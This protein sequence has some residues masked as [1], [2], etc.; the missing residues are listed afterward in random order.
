MKKK[1]NL[2]LKI[3]VLLLLILWSPKVI[4]ADDDIDRDDNIQ[5]I[6]SG[7]V[8]SNPRYLYAP[9]ILYDE[10]EKLFKLWACGNRGG[11]NIIYKQ[12]KTIDK[13]VND[14]WKIA[15]SPSRDDKSFDDD[16]TCDPSVIQVEN[17]YYLYYTG[18]NEDKDESWNKIGV[19]VSSDGGRTFTRL[20]SINPIIEPDSSFQGGYGTGQQAVTYRNGWYYMVYTDVE[21]GQPDKIQVIKSKS[22]TFENI[23]FIKQLNPSIKA[24]GPRGLSLDLAYNPS[25]D[26]FILV[27]NVST[28]GR[29]KVLITSY[30]ASD[31][32]YIEQSIF[33]HETNFRFGEG[34]G[35]LRNSSGEIGVYSKSG[36]H[37]FVFVAST[38]SPAKTRK[39]CENLGYT[40]CWVRGPM[41]FLIFTEDRKGLF[42]NF[43][44][45]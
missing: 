5:F 17:K 38:W 39:E 21:K 45:N 35:I 19:A 9:S 40:K 42:L 23:N 24:S 4:S 3:I 37:A 13:L 1:S 41:K 2:N 32:N 10:T 28:P 16:H 6:R 7:T 34:I 44:S 27:A 8:D 26:E 25:R 43:S 36:K 30:T 22:P 33:A 31:W 12:A 11:D 18:W 14:E 29:S 20:N 15:L